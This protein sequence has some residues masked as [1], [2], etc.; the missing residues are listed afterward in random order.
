M[1]NLDVVL[2]ALQQERSRLTAQLANVGKAIAALGAPAPRRKSRKRTSFAA[3]LR[4]IRAGQK[5]R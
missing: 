5:K 3:A 4:R 2:K 1:S